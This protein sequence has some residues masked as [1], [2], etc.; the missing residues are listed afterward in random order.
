MHFQIMDAIK[1]KK[2]GLSLQIKDLSTKNERN[3][4][5]AYKASRINTMMT[6]LKHKLKKKN[7]KLRILTNNLVAMKAE[8]E[9][10]CLHIYKMDSM[11]VT[12]T[13]SM[14]NV[15]KVIFYSYLLN[16]VLW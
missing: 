11:L 2:I 16:S 15:L 5:I 14:E 8:I 3:Q 12:T 13:K 10:L 1:A 9:T 4:R 7:K 6:Q